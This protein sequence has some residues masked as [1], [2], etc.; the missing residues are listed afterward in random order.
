MWLLE[1][2]VGHTRPFVV[3]GEEV[4]AVVAGLS[5]SEAEVWRAMCFLGRWRRHCRGDWSLM[6]LFEVAF[7]VEGAA[8]VM[9]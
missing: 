1:G 5:V 2:S 6:A 4:V 8:L 3:A 7:E 9:C